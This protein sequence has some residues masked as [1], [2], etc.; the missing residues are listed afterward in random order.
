[1]WGSRKTTYDSLA[2]EGT[3]TS[4]Q[5][6]YI[7]YED[8]AKTEVIRICSE[9]AD[10]NCTAEGDE[11]CKTIFVTSMTTLNYQIEISKA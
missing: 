4:P 3:I 10:R 5:E 1:M 9:K 7:E 8:V 6:C 2:N 11:I